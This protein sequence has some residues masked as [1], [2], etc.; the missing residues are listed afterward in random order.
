MAKIKRQGLDNIRERNF[1]NELKGLKHQPNPLLTERIDR[2]LFSLDGN[3]LYRYKPHTLAAEEYKRCL[4]LFEKRLP[5]EHGKSTM[6]AIAAFGDRLMNSISLHIE[7]Q[8]LIHKDVLEQLAVDTIREIFDV[9]E[10]VK[11]L[12]NLNVSLELDPKQQKNPQLS[13]STE[14]KLKMR[15]EIQKRIILNGL[16]HG[17]AMHIWKSAHHIIRDKIDELDPMLMTMYNEYTA[18]IGWLIWMIPPDAAEEAVL[19]KGNAQAMTQGFNQLKF[20]ED[21]GAEV[22]CHAV[23]FPVLLHEVAKGA[24]DYLICRGIP[25]EYDEAQLEYYYAKADAYEHEI[26]HY[27]MSPTL[28]TKLLSAAQVP[29]QDLPSVISNLTQLSYQELTEVLRGCIDG[30]DTG[31]MKLK[32]FKIVQ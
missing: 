16:V 31:Q 23:N 2:K 11:L 24:I 14:E 30:Q 4:E 13:L 26:W 15:D 5:Y 9:P 18:G 22:H 6:E 19:G 29:S 7:T 21:H 1:T 17:A 32:Q 27:L 10:H 12:P 8:E 20:E 3:N 28:W 25:Q